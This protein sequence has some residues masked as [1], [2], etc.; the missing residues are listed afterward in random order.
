MLRRFPP[1][2]T[3]IMAG[4]GFRHHYATKT[5]ALTPEVTFPKRSIS[6]LECVLRFCGSRSGNA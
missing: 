3:L 4:S 6:P 5:I 2:A 1:D